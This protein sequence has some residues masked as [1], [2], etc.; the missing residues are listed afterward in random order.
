MTQSDTNKHTSDQPAP[1]AATQ[2]T[3]ITTDENRCL[4]RGFEPAFP[5]IKRLQSHA[6]DRAANGIGFFVLHLIHFFLSS[7]FVSPLLHIHS[8]LYSSHTAFRL[9]SRFSRS[10]IQAAKKFQK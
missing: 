8:S 6:L 2:H 10:S 5:A 4:K 9:S 7:P 1:D 3:K